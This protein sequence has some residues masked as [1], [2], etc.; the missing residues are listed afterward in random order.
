MFRC[1]PG[2]QLVGLDRVPL[3]GNAAVDQGTGDFRAR[4]QQPTQK[5]TV[6]RLGLRPSSVLIFT[7]KTP[8]A[9]RD[10]LDQSNIQHATHTPLGGRGA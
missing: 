4:D 9:R 8:Q 7:E 1:D 2:G 6:V 5:R 3:I 10:E